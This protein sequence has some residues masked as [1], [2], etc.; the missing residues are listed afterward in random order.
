MTLA[1]AYKKQNIVESELEKK[2]EQLKCE[3]C[4]R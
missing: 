2:E 1:E 4:G 3:Y